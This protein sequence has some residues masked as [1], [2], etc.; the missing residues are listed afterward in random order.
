MSCFENSLYDCWE[1]KNNYFLHWYLVGVRLLCSS[2]SL[3]LFCLFH[4]WFFV[5]VFLYFELIAFRNNF[6][7]CSSLVSR[8]M[9]EVLS[10]KVVVFFELSINLMSSWSVVWNLHSTVPYLTFSKSGRGNIKYKRKL[11]KTF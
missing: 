11:S 1:W 3:F 8:H 7:L 4:L 10:A 6:L 2:K 5:F 9:L